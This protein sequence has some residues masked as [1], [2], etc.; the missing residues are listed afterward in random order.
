M[1]NSAVKSHH[2]MN[3]IYVNEA[4]MARRIDY[5]TSFTVNLTDSLNKSYAD[6]ERLVHFNT[7]LR[8][9]T[10]ISTHLNKY[11]KTYFASAH[12][13]ILAVDLIPT[14]DLAVLK[15]KHSFSAHLGLNLA[16]DSLFENLKLSQT[17]I[18]LTERG[19]NVNLCF[20]FMLYTTDKYF[21]AGAYGSII[22]LQNE[23]SMRFMKYDIDNPSEIK[24]IKNNFVFLANRKIL[25]FKQKSTSWKDESQRSSNFK[26]ISKTTFV[27]F[28]KIEAV[29]LCGNKRNEITIQ[30]NTLSLIPE[31]CSLSSTSFEIPEFKI[32]STQHAAEKIRSLS[33][34]SKPLIQT[35]NSFIST[36]LRPEMTSSL[37]SDLPD[38]PFDP[39]LYGPSYNAF[40]NRFG[41]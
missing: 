5:L 17:N 40:L 35:N 32:F 26:L 4:S 19:K 31:H 30:A 38:V 3:K 24:L 14:K 9:Y 20:T 12:N 36:P 41:E 21:Y 18:F 8:Y 22:F 11:V 6:K 27:S 7:L 34:F 10:D 29:Y 33:Y 2:I 16:T 39:I 28:E 1:E 15:L 23:K 13:P 37:T 25:Y